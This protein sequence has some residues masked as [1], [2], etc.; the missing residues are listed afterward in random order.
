[1]TTF[2]A[3][4]MFFTDPGRERE[5]LAEQLAEGMGRGLKPDTMGREWLSR[6]KALAATAGVEVD[7]VLKDLERDAWGLR[8]SEFTSGEMFGSPVLDDATA[9]RLKGECFGVTGPTRIQIQEAY[10][11]EKA[12]MGGD[13]IHKERA[14]IRKIEERFGISGVV[15][16]SSGQIAGW[17][18]EASFSAAECF[19][20]T[21]STTDLGRKV[22]LGEECR[23]VKVAKDIG[24]NP[25]YALKGA[26]GVLC[27][28][29]DP[30]ALEAWGEE[31]RLKITGIENFSSP[32]DAQPD[33][34]A[35][36]EMF[37]Y[38]PPIE[39]GDRVVYNGKHGEVVRVKNGRAEVQLDG[40]RAVQQ[41]SV[42]LDVLHHE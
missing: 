11:S 34:F 29:S 10:E 33:G 39:V 40:E 21:V 15:V 24:G 12:A 3:G 7:R 26:A 14:A 19:A 5:R 37:E 28:S 42:S 18:G 20:A 4:E 38:E 13:D 27:I 8:G 6:V 36:G 23:I 16:N 30:D 25:L 31:R 1:M 35:A 32:G 22:Y 41:N 17:T 9:A 2:S